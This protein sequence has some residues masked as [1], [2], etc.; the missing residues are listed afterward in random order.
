VPS[1]SPR[2][3]K[4]TA[5]FSGGYAAYYRRKRV[6]I[7]N[8]VLSSSRIIYRTPRNHCSPY[9]RYISWHTILSFLPSDQGHRKWNEH[10]SNNEGCF[11]RCLR[12]YRPRNYL[13]YVYGAN[14]HDSG[15]G[16][17]HLLQASLGDD[18]LVHYSAEKFEDLTVSTFS[19]VLSLGG[20]IFS[21]CVLQSPDPKSH[22][23][24][25]EHIN[26][27]SLAYEYGL[28]CMKNA[29]LVNK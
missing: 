20:S 3:S 18:M 10:R 23:M 2:K 24:K 17:L 8:S 22:L 21:C 25:V 14:L 26:T 9:R 6:H 7:H 29:D 12:S 28:H 5:S 27:P 4:L 16:C 11:S 1:K 13:W 19:R 15:A